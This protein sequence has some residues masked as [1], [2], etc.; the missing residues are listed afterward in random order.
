MIRTEKLWKKFPMKRDT[1]GFKEFISNIPR[2]FMK[3]TDCFW[4]LKNIN[5]RVE[6]GQCLGVIGRNGAG[7]STLLSIL[8]GGMQPTKGI[9]S[10]AGRKTPLLELGAGFNPEMTGTENIIINGVLLGSTE[11]EIRDRMEDV[12]AFSELGDFIKMPI[13]TYS[14]GMVMRLAFSVAIHTDP[15]IFLIDEILAVGDE[16]FQEKSRVALM[17]LITSGVTTVYVSHSMDAIKSICDKAIWIDHGEIRDE[18]EPGIIIEKYLKSL[19]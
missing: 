16:S 12:I 3:N 9:V 17:N 1:P 14:S 4:A 13:R 2:F 5:L 6:R 19:N 11:K 7:K 18:G 10:V 15:E 8:L